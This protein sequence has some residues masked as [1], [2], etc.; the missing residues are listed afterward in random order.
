MTTEAP[1]AAPEP[2]DNG[3]V[4][5][6]GAFG[7]GCGFNLTGTGVGVGNH[8][9]LAIGTGGDPFAR[10]LEQAQ[11]TARMNALR[12][13]Y[14][15]NSTPK[16]TR[17]VKDTD[18]EPWI[19]PPKGSRSKLRKKPKGLYTAE[20]Y[21]PS[22]PEPEVIYKEK[23]VVRTKNEWRF[24][25]DTH[26]EEPKWRLTLYVEDVAVQ[27]AWV[28][29][30][31]SAFTTCSISGAL[32]MFWGI[33]QAFTDGWAPLTPGDAL[34]AYFTVGGLAIAM[35]TLALFSFKRRLRRTRRK[36]LMRYLKSRFEDQLKGF[37]DNE[38]VHW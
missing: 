35:G 19:D 4:Y 37:G 29:T 7:G 26:R 1:P 32:A 18:D 27:R 31:F 21:V 28:N 14:E 23:V 25:W 9:G 8:Y 6:N 22:K 34:T 3:R 24:H 11:Q 17:V 5:P 2:N 30:G 10:L 12:A 16:E 15:K 20:G 33:Y 38:N 13:E 36:M